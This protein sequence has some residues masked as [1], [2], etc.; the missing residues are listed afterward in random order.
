MNPTTKRITTGAL[1]AALYIVT[2]ALNPIGYGIIQLRL[3]AIISLVPFYRKEYQLPCIAA[4]AIANWFSPLGVIDVAVGIILW[5]LAYYIVDRVCGNLYFKCGATALLSGVLIGGELAF[6]LRAPF[7]LN[8]IS[9]A[10]SQMIVFSIGIICLDRL[11]RREP[12]HP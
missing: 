7:V 9:I 3:S 11:F 6:V 1:L 4:V 5:T 2:T 12:A 10:A 8:F